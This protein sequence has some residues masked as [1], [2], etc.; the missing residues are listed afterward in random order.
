MLAA[1]A[2]D[3]VQEVC[4]KAF[5]QLDELEAMQYPRAWLLKVLY[6]Q[7][8]DAQRVGR[9]SPVGLADTGTDSDE[10]DAIAASDMGLEQQVDTDIRIERVLRAMQCLSG[11][12]CAIVAL[13]DIEGMTVE[14]IGEITGLAAGTVKSKLH[15]TR[16]KLGKLVGNDVLPRPRLRAIGNGR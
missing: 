3:L 7:F 1:D 5:E 12:Q 4:I 8:I 6:H 9:R 14:E 13:H 2:E 11:D 10:P 15:R 16:A